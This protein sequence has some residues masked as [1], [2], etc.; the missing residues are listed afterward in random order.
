MAKKVDKPES[1]EES[2]NDKPVV[3]QPVEVPKPKHA[4][5]RPT[6]Y[7]PEYCEQIIE[8]FSGELTKKLKKKITTKQGAVIEEEIE[9]AND[10][11]TL[12]SFARKIG[13]SRQRLYEWEKVHPEF[14]DALSRARELGENF[15]VQNAITGRYNPKAFVFIAQNYT[16]M[17]DKLEHTGEGGGPL[18][19]I[20]KGRNDKNSSGSA[21]TGKP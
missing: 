7:R 3:T 1:M 6:D 17:R 12:V 14:K 10:L 21:G 2:G 5:G 18:A 19:I 15:M 13:T 11:P 9:V 8:F 4:G 16:P 20:I